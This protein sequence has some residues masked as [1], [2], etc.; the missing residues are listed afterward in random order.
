MSQHTHG[1]PDD[2]PPERRGERLSGIVLA[3]S[4]PLAAFLALAVGLLAA[5][6][7]PFGGWIPWLV[8]PLLVVSLGG[9]VRLVRLV[10]AR[11][12]PV[13]VA[14]AVLTVATGHGL[15]AGLTHAGHVVLRR[16]AGSY[17]LYSQWIATR[18]G[19]P[20]SSWLEA[21]GGGA[22][23]TDPAFRLSSPT[24]Y[25]VVHGAAGAAGTTVDIVPQ[26]LLGAPAMYSLGWWAAGW[27]GLLVMPAICSALALLG[28]AGLAARLVGPRSAVAATACLGWPSRCCTRPAPPTPSRSRCSWSRSPRPC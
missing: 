8:L 25:Q 4:G 3:R 9:A 28:F 1:V 17:A 23:L 21:F 10:P 19:L 12:A 20:V 13:W 26:F 24:Y 6:L 15:W 7:V 16:D 2:G 22:A 11:P 18:H 14:P 27:N 5:L